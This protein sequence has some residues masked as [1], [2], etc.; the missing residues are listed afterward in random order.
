MPNGIEINK[1]NFKTLGHDE[2]LEIIFENVL[3]IKKHV[4]LQPGLCEAEMDNKIKNN[5]K[6][7]RRVTI[8]LSGSAGAGVITIW[9]VAKNIPKWWNGG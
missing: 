9:E 4:L 8:G 2:R 7:R 1:E 3:A 6:M 5:N